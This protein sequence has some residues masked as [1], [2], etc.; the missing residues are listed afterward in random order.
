MKNSFI[1]FCLVLFAMVLYGCD[2]KKNADSVTDVQAGAA[3]Y[4]PEIPDASV[5]E[6]VPVIPEV[7]TN[8]EIVDTPPVAVKD[9]APDAGLFLSELFPDNDY[10][11][12]EEPLN[13]NYRNIYFAVHYINSVLEVCD[14]I[15]GYEI[16]DGVF[17]RYLLIQDFKFISEDDSV[18]CDFSEKYQGIYGFKLSY[19]YPQDP[20]YK[21]GLYIDTYFDVGKRI[22]DGF[23]ISWNEGIKQFELVSFF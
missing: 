9:T 21:P 10:I 20:E 23:T 11:L 1:L 19:S 3:D 18:F 8:P 4:K 7:S 5:H 13:V 2:S 16:V 17:H 15:V 14:I 12:F 6:G 22:A